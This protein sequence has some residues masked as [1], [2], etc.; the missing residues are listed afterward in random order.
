MYRGGEARGISGSLR[1]TRTAR[2]PSASASVIID[3]SYVN[4]PFARPFAQ[5]SN[6]IYNL[7]YR[8]GSS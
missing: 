8:N 7:P 2:R 3:W 6:A 4:F 1:S 5:A